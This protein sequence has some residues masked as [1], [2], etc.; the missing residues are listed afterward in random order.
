MSITDSTF[1]HGTK[2]HPEAQRLE[3][4][5]GKDPCTTYQKLVEIIRRDGGVVVKGLISREHA[6]RI[7]AELKSTYEADTLDQSGFFPSTTRRA[8]GLLGVS[9]GCVELATHKLWIDVCNAILTSTCSP[10]YGEKRSTFTSKPI[11]AGTFGFQIHPGTRQQDLHRDDRYVMSG[12]LLADT[13]VLR[14]RR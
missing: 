12:T 4:L 1:S 9:D 2:D 6:E 10:W 14:V 3:H 5:D 13:V 8:T 11:L 7:R